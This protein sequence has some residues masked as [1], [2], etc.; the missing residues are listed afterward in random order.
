MNSTAI[1]AG[2][3]DPLTLGHCDLIARAA[4]IFP[5]LILAVAA[6]PNKEA[7]FS[8]EERVALARESLAD[9][10]NV[11]VESFSGLLVH[12]VREQGAHVLLR[13][14][15]AVSDFQYEFEMAL[16][17]RQLAPEVETLFLM[18]KQDYSYVSSSSVREIAGLGGDISLLVPPPVRKALKRKIAAQ[19]KP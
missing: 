15:R 7:F 6:N 5:K 16:T 13:G 12:Y 9:L 2:T 8:P 19:R 1:Y 3:F 18:P 10:S 4:R 14:L 11:V 17:N